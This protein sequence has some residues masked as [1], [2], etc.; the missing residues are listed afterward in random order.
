MFCFDPG[1]RGRFDRVGDLTEACGE[2][3]QKAIVQG[4]SHVN[5]VEAGGKL[6]F[7]TH[8]GYYS[9]IDGMEKMGMPPAGWKPYP[10]GHLLAYDMESGRFDESGRGPGARGHPHHEHGHQAR[11]HLRPD[12]AHRHLL[13][14]RPGPKGT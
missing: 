1:P 7:A 9:I 11:P 14:L 3:G 4:K 5:F 8:I 10:G 13:P 2:K 12:L 6:Y